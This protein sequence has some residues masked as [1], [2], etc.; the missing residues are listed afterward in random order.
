[1]RI[2]ASCETYS[3]IFI[4][5][6]HLSLKITI[7]WEEIL[8]SIK[9]AKYLFLNIIYTY[10]YIIFYMMI[11]DLTD[12][13]FDKI[14]DIRNRLSKKTTNNIINYTKWKIFKVLFG[15]ETQLSNEETTKILFENTKDDT[16]NKQKTF[17]EKL[18]NDFPTFAK[19]ETRI[20]KWW[21]ISK[22]FFHNVWWYVPTHL[23]EDKRF[24]WIHKNFKNK[25]AEA[26]FFVHET[27][28][29]VVW[30]TIEVGN[31]KELPEE[32]QKVF[33]NMKYIYDNLNKTKNKKTYKLSEKEFIKENKNRSFTAK[34]ASMFYCF[35]NFQEFIAEVFSNPMLQTHL[36]KIKNKEKNIFE[37]LCEWMDTL[38]DSTAFKT[39]K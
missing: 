15:Q 29:Q 9:I 24:T 21:Y 12:K 26:Y 3:F 10:L 38:F 13:K 32:K 39:I 16:L 8:K 7:F 14:E 28:H 25:E 1:M 2:K 31:T 36:K 11:V 22:N 5:Q 20:S 27:I 18:F 17:L 34:W 23:K 4:Y 37:T 35:T 33:D 6:S 19:K 30:D